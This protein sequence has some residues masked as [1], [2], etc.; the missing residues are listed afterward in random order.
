MNMKHFVVSALLGRIDYGLADLRGDVAGGLV[1]GFLLIPVALSLG[2]LSGLGPVAGLYGALAVGVFGALVG[3]TR[4][5]IS[6]PNPNVTII[7][8]LVVAE[9]ST[10]VSEAL[11]VAV[12]AGLIQIMFGLLRFGRYISY[13]PASLLD[14]FFTGVGMLIVTI[15]I[16]PAMGLASVGGGVIGAVKALP[17][18]IANMNLDAVLV[19]VISLAAMV[20]WRGPLSRLA[21]SQF[22]MFVTGTLVGI[23]WLRDAPAI[24]TIEVGLSVPRLPELSLG[25][26]LRA[27]QPAFMIALMS[28]IGILI[29]AMLVDSITGRQQQPNRLL[30]GHGMGNMAAGLIGGPSWR[31]GQ[32]NPCQCAHRRADSGIQSDGDRDGAPGTFHRL[33]RSHRTNPESCSGCDPDSQWVEHN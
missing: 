11:A 16:L 18:A 25:F 10:S 7:M 5:I 3:G 26:L 33:E 20:L 29:G 31:W 24:G 28:S 30:V 12:L 32:W 27:V 15:Q 1:S 13:V 17:S 22:V 6:G 21:P 14:G 2:T 8:A 23:F 19:T 9:Y 4:G